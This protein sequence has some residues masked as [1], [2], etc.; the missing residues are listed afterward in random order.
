MS[1]PAGEAPDGNR[2]AE[3]ESELEQLALRLEQTELRA[4]HAYAEAENAQA[5]LRFAQERG[6]APQGAGDGRMRAD[7]AAAMERA[8]AAEEKNSALRAELLLLKKG[9]DTAVP[10]EDE[11]SDDN[12]FADPEDDGVSLRTRLTRAVDSKRATGDDS[13]QWR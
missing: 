11:T 10:L 3:L 8:Q 6:E 13:D 12:G 2:V 7:L 5:E 4:R 9:M 1:T